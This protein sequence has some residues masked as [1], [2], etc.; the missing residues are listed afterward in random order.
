MLLETRV[1]SR[2]TPLD[3]RLEV[4]RETLATLAALGAELPLVSMGRASRATLE[5][6]PCT[7]ARGAGAAHEHHFVVSPAFAS[8]EAG[9][10]VR[11]QLTDDATLHVDR[12]ESERA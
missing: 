3:G 9:S 6:M 4:S 7:C 12:A 1:V 5:T 2:K 10:T 8:L 11:V